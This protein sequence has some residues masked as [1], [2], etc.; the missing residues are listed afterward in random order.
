ML[1]KKEIAEMYR[2]MKKVHRLKTSRKEALRYL[3]LS[4]RDDRF[5]KTA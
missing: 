5:R 3:D 1:T 2:L 4:R